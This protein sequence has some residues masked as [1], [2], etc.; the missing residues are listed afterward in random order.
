MSSLLL[1]YHQWS[2]NLSMIVNG[3]LM[4]VIYQVGQHAPFFR[5]TCACETVHVMGLLALGPL[6]HGPSAL[7][8]AKSTF[9]GI[10]GFNLGVRE[11]NDKALYHL[12]C[13]L[14]AKKLYSW[15]LINLNFL[16]FILYIKVNWYL[17]YDTKFSGIQVN[18]TKLQVTIFLYYR[19]LIYLI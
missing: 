10:L 3:R 9:I 6:R 13:K 4:W 2:R 14:W 8:P 5:Q 16:I 15:T 19:I 7:H 12:N 17:A 11:I 1:A 18:L